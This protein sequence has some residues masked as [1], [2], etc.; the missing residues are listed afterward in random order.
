MAQ[1]KL[2]DDSSGGAISFYSHKGK[3]KK[4][5]LVLFSY[6]NTADAETKPEETTGDHSRPTETTGDHGDEARETTG[7]P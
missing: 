4:S 6:Q 3:N 5:R 2:V 7:I 1:T